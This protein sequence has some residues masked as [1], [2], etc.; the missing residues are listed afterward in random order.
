MK[1]GHEIET[2]VRFSKKMVRE[3]LTDKAKDLSGQ[4]GLNTSELVFAQATEEADEFATVSFKMNG[5]I[6]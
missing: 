6:K 5:A 2:V 3:I 1:N 4:K